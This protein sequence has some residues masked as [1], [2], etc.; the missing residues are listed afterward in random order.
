MNWKIGQ[1][2]VCIEDNSVVAIML[3]LRVPKKDEIVT[4]DGETG[5]MDTIF[6]VEYNYTHLGFKN[7]GSRFNMARHCF[8]P[9][10]GQSAT[11]ELVSSFIEITETS[12]LPI[13]SPQTTEPCG[14]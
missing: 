2:L 5:M 9:I 8:R 1:K 10:L 11:A 4:Y 6:L 12:D 7:P 14:L 13:R 3:G